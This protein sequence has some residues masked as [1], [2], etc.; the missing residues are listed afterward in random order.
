MVISDLAKTDYLW[1]AFFKFIL[2]SLNGYLWETIFRLIMGI[3]VNNYP[4]W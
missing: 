2:V 4:F 1:G 3:Q